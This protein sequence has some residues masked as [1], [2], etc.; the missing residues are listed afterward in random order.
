[1]SISVCIKLRA[2]SLHRG[3]CA[4]V[5][6]SCNIGKH[7]IR[8]L[9][10]PPRSRPSTESPTLPLGIHENAMYENER[11]NTSTLT[12]VRRFF[13][14]IFPEHFPAVCRKKLI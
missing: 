11:N 6:A 14:F 13:Q 5:G 8:I 1:M 3:G 2:V 10:H 7:S 12:Y 9:N 4:V